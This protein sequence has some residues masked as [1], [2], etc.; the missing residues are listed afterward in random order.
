[1]RLW[2]GRR[3]FLP[4]VV[5]LKERNPE[6]PDEHLCELANYRRL[7]SLQGGCIPWLYGEAKVHHGSTT[8]SALLL[9]FVDGQRLDRLPP[10]DLTSD[11]PR[12]APKEG[13][14]DI[15]TSNCINPKLVAAI[16]HVYD[17]ME[18]M[19][20]AHGDPQPH[21]FLA[22]VKGNGYK[23]TALD[24]EFSGPPDDPQTKAM[25]LRSVFHGI[26]DII[27]PEQDL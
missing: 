7:E 4:T 24:F 3:G 20:M 2:L 25:E 14:R 15:L 16:K 12:Q 6:R 10:G 5:V 19:G 21:N 18:E 8:V 27:D 11:Q 13:P 26:S 17:Q 22:T 1:M 9:E 23:V